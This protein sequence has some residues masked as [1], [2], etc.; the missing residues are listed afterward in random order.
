MR[1]D[2]SYI[3]GKLAEKMVPNQ[4]VALFLLALAKT[5]AH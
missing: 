4:S 3:Q 1:S 5:L 2:V